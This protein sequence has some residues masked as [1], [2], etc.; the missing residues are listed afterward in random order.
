[1]PPAVPPPDAPDEVVARLI[2]AFH[3]RTP[4]RIWSLV[5]TVF[6]DMVMPR[7]GVIG[8]SSLTRLCGLMAI[9][10]TA[11]RPAM[12][13]LTADGL[14]I[15]EKQGRNTY[16]RLSDSAGEAFARASRRIYAPSS[17]AWVGDW[18]AVVIVTR[19]ASERAA[20]RSDLLDQGFG[21]LNGTVLLRAG[22]D[23]GF[24]APDGAV[25]LSGQ[26]MD[27]MP[28]DLKALA[29]TAWPLDALGRRYDGFRDRYEGLAR[30]IETGPPVSADEAV[31]ARTLLIHDYRRLSL[32]DPGLPAALLPETWPGHAARRMTAA[33]YA[34]L[35]APSEAWLDHHGTT[36]AGPLPALSP[37]F[38]GRFR[39]GFMAS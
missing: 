19:D 13:R 5:V 31:I 26:A 18:T 9:G 33:L 10:G 4:P 8:L 7:G 34:A 23:H 20:L 15:R 2:A 36:P 37:E 28:A 30:R 32:N 29:A 21:D 16:Y 14:L 39:T 35:Q 24:T 38:H 12:S 11:L 22:T 25:T 17:P 1:M 3:A 27:A 6:G